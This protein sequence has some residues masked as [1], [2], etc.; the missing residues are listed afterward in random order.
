MCHA[1]FDFDAYVCV[2]TIWWVRPVEA[3]ERTGT[4]AAAT[5]TTIQRNGRNEF[6]IEHYQNTSWNLHDPFQTIAKRAGLGK[7]I[8]PFDNMRMSRSNEVERRFGAKKE[9]LWIGHSEKVML[10]HYHVLEDGDYLEA[11]GKLE[12]QISHAPHHA[13][14]LVTDSKLE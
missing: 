11:A 1:G 4:T 7:I 6:V 3:N 8:R 9:S 2:R 10:K 13:V 5:A 14:S 12:S